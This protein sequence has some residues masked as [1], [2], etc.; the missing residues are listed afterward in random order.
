MM[1]APMML[2]TASPA[3]RTSSK[4]ADDAARRL[5]LRQQLHRD[6]DGDG[7]HAFAADDDA[8]QV[9][10]GRVKRFRAELDRLAGGREAAHLEHVVQGQART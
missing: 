8:E 5:R 1:P 7:E 2:A 10:P 4:L 9:E 6:L 3:R